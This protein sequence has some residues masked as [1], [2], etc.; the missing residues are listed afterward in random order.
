MKKSDTK[1]KF[2][3]NKLLELYQEDLVV[4]REYLYDNF[5]VFLYH[6]GIIINDLP[7]RKMEDVMVDMY[8]RVDKW[9]GKSL[10]SW[11]KVWQIYNYIKRRLRGEL[12]NMWLAREPT[13]YLH[14]WFQEDYMH[15]DFDVEDLEKR[16]KT[17]AIRD[18]MFMLSPVSQQ[19]ILLRYI[20]TKKFTPQ[21]VSKA[22]WIPYSEFSMYE[23]R[24]L[25]ELKNLV[26]NAVQYHEETS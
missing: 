11:Y 14:E 22:C 17:E 9:I 1:K 12:I 2:D 26:F 6:S 3:M 4:W 19:I 16:Y 15:Y 20:T 21:Q 5:N 8:I 10:H 18:A 24:A 25:Q 13:E 23:E 7:Q